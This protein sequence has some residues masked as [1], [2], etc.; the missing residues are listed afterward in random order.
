MLASG[1]LAFALS[2]AVVTGPLALTGCA[3]LG[4]EKPQNFEERLAGGY[5][6]VSAI[7]A[8]GQQLALAGKIGKADAQDIQAQADTARAALDITAQIHDTDPTA[9]ENRL[10]ATIIALTALQA[11][12]ASKG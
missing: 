9:A 2:A 5:A 7:R 4:V 8:S 12:L 10:N 3:A 1:V 6:T 11:Y